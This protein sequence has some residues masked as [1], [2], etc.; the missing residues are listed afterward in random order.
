VNFYKKHFFQKLLK[1]LQK[2][3]FFPLFI[4]NSGIRSIS[5]NRA[6][7]QNRRSPFFSDFMYRRVTQCSFYFL[8]L[9]LFYRLAHMVNMLVPDTSARIETARRIEIKYKIHNS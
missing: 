4:W 1:A 2:E 8:L 7:Y 9:S 3:I 6:A 5:H